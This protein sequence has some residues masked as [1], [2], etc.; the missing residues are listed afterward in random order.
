MCNSPVVDDCPGRSELWY[1]ELMDGEETIRRIDGYLEGRYDVREYPSLRAQVERFR[2]ARPFAGRSLLDCTPVFANTLLKYV[3]LLAGGADLTVS[4]SERIP[5]DP[6][7]VRFLDE[8]GIPVLRDSADAARPFAEVLPVPKG[9]GRNYDA[10]YDYLTEY[11]PGLEIAFANASASFRTLRRV[12]AD[13]ADDTP[14]L[15]V[16]FA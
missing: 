9:Y 12:C 15:K 13:A 3:A 2:A 8:I 14:G 16:V 5:H 7:V 6:E 4:V 10:L 1:N 11:G